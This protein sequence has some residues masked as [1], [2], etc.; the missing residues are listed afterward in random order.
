[1]E[2]LIINDI[3]VARIAIAKWARNKQNE[4]IIFQALKF[5][6]SCAL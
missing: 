4:K 1:M 6:Y 3:H 2:N 5:P